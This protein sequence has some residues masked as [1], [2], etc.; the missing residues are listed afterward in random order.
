LRQLPSFLENLDPTIY[1]S[2]NYVV[3]DFEI[4]TSHGDFGNP[5]HP[6][7]QMLLASWKIGPAHEGSTLFGTLK[8]KWGSEYDLDELMHDIRQADFLV[9]HNAKYELGWLK[10]AGLDLHNVLVF[11]TKIGEYVLLGNMAAGD[12]TMLPISTSLDVCAQRRGFPPKDPVVDILMKHG[13]NPVRMPRE[14]LQGR[15]EQDVV[16]TEAVFLDQRRRLKAT[17]RLPV[18]YTR[19]L[20]TPV[21]ADIESEGMALNPERV[22]EEYVKAVAELQQLEQ[23]L[24]AMTGGINWR[25][26]KQSGEYLY[27]TLKF[28]EL[29]KP[30]GEPKRTKKSARYPD[31]QRMTDQKTLAL[32]KAHTPE[33][34]SFLKLRSKIG[35]VSFLLSKNLEFF[36]GVCNE[37]GGT[38]YAEFNQTSTATNRLSSSGIELKFTSIKT[39]Q[40]KDSTK[41]V[42]FQNLPRRLKRLFRAKRAGWLL[43]EPDGAQLEFRVAVELAYAHDM[44]L[45]REGKLSPNAVDMQGI[46]DIEDPNWDAHVTSAAA[47]EG[48]PY[49]ALYERY[50]AGE[51]KATEARQNAKPETF[52]P[53]YGG[54]K[55]TPKQERWYKEFRRR[56]PGIARL[57]DAWVE[58]VVQTK[59]LITPWGLRF[60]WPYA[61]R[62]GRDG[63]VNVTTAVS[64]YPVQ[65]LATAEIIP[66]A[67]VYL[68]HRLQAEDLGKFIRIV[69]TVH[70]SAPC[71]VE[72]GHVDD[73]R[74]IVKQSFTRDVY[75]F[76][77]KVYGLDF[78]VPLGV[79]LKGGEHLGEGKEELYNVWK[80]GREVRVK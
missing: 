1:L 53:L 59:R 61:R 8:S 76:L 42:Q 17:G 66:I 38:F 67:L 13:I 24:S 41:R 65:S 51:E 68:W 78:T 72:P 25:S 30:N 54:R 75:T 40:D 15:C 31:G 63:Y 80:D 73:F 23:E 56:Y 26:G 43:F 29:R 34:R 49:E 50:K 74:R 4:D 19:C 21:L 12:E 64:N 46:K 58:E 16:S 3:L 57:Q 55:G 28:D 6:D 11:D 35:K 71:E 69:N 44:K 52:K 9:A 22:Q 27:D 32:L 39:K 48:V 20:L 77:E 62:S 47:M 79:G 7:N 33:Q 14:W 36:Q 18:L 5:V 37:Y 70:D 45:V 10:R 2:D 60:Y